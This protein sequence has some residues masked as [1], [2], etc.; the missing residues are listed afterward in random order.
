MSNRL[1]RRDF[2]KATG[3][4]AAAAAST[5]FSP[6]AFASG[7]RQDGPRLLYLIRQ[8]AQPDAEMVQ[9]AMSEMMADRIGATIELRFIE[10]GAYNDQMA[11]INAAAEEY[12]LVYT[13]P[14][15]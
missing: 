13:A 4:A 2:L 15:D 9:S 3:A 12:D 14:L 11:L 8:Q 10:P 5:Q 7:R 1:S 6:I